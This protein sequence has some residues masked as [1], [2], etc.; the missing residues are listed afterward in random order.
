ML[1]PGALNAHWDETLKAAGGNV[2]V[3]EAAFKK[4][5]A[6]MTQAQGGK[7]N[8]VG[9]AIRRTFK[10][11][12]GVT[13][14]H[15]RTAEEALQVA[16]NPGAKL[17]L[18]RRRIR[19]KE[20]KTDAVAA[21]R[22]SE[23]KT[24]VKS[25]DDA[26]MKRILT[27]QGYSGRRVMF[28]KNNT[29]AEQAA[30]VKDRTARAER[31][32]NVGVWEHINPKNRSANK[33]LNKAEEAAT[34]AVA[35]ETEQ[36]KKLTPDDQVAKDIG[37]VTREGQAA[38][39]KAD[40]AVKQARDTA[41][42]QAPSLDAAAAN[43]AAGRQRAVNTM[44]E[45]IVNRSTAGEMLTPAE[46]AFLNARSKAQAAKKRVDDLK[47]SSTST[48]KERK[49]AEKALNKAN[50]EV[51]KATAGA[52][53]KAEAPIPEAAPTGTLMPA[54]TAP[55]P[56]L[57]PQAAVQAG[58]QQAA[59]VRNTAASLGATFNSPA[60]QA[61]QA[62][63]AGKGRGV[64][65]SLMGAGVLGT[66]ALVHQ[67]F[68]GQATPQEQALQDRNKSIANLSPQ[69]QKLYRKINWSTVGNPSVNIGGRTFG[70]REILLRK[71]VVPETVR[72]QV[73]EVMATGRAPLNL[74]VNPGNNQ[75][76]AA[77][78]HQMPSRPP[79]L[80]QPAG[81]SGVG[82]GAAA[83]FVPAQ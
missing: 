72:Q 40:L 43:A 57:D 45:D 48:P 30:V 22:G 77:P 13:A 58:R 15:A 42:A 18:T 49:A 41:T 73:E 4:R 70:A 36:F 23:G 71:V 69:E 52:M 64:A 9:D 74:V 17:A 28:G 68:A 25:L 59:N 76:Q 50:R 35:R 8:A 16:K 61:A 53:P 11:K 81:A 3:A 51:K 2:A 78:G 56:S 55:P 37:R 65:R 27:E 39:A 66:A 79:A 19:D 63:R 67:H 12:D 24:G 31:G 47:A 6:G 82:T 75:L 83:L 46:T 29:A 7:A 33:R 26:A 44:A 32:E 14:S 34:E 54:G 21:L 80:R 5:L 60:E 10:G 38:Q 1:D 62:A 20:L